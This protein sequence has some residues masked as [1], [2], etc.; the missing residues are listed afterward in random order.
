MAEALALESVTVAFG[1]L[2]AVDGV[3]LA[4]P[5]GERR[6]IIG[7]NGAGKTTLFGA[8]TGLVRATGGRVRFAGEDITRLPPHRRARRGIARTFQITNLFPSLTVRENLFL[9][10]RGLSRGKFACFAQPVPTAE[11]A[12]RAGAALAAAHLPHRADAPV[13]ALSYGEQRQVELAL[14]IA[15]SPRLLLLDEP[16]AGLSPTERAMVAEVIR[17]LPRSITLVLIEHDMDLVLGLVD[18]VTCLHEGRVLVEA[19]PEAIRSDAAVQEV[20]LG[21]P[22]EHAHA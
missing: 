2:R 14:A 7:P 5:E 12:R 22:R 6:A 11:E 1:A 15:G 21:R 17:G 20:Y 8:I 9:A 10:L 3:S 19:P 18:R 13:S 4:V 16:A